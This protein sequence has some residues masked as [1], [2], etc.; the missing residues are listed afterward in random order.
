MV[1]ELK[2]IMK[3]LLSYI[4]PLTKKRISDFSGTLEITLINGNKVL[5]SVNA[6]YSYGSLQQIL[7]YGIT[8]A[9]INFENIGQLLILG[10]GGG[11]VIKSLREKFRYLNKIDAVEIDQKIIAIAQKEFD[12]KSSDYLNIINEDAFSFVFNC[13]QYY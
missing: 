10:L 6:N 9:E 12:I 5:D 4:I 11:S 8:K 3:K 7:E 1:Q 2:V 13:C